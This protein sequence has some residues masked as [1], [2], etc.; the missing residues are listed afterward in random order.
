MKMISKA[1]TA[2]TLAIVVSAGATALTTTAAVIGAS[3]GLTALSATTAEAGPYQY[4]KKTPH[5]R[6]GGTAGLPLG[7]T[8]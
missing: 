8:R 7:N 3:A 6:R 5:T 4:P 2:A 1:I